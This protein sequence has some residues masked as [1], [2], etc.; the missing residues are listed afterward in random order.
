MPVKSEVPTIDV[1]EILTQSLRFSGN[2]E[3]PP[4]VESEDSNIMA[5]DFYD[6]NLNSYDEGPG[7]DLPQQHQP[8]AM[9]KKSKKDNR[10]RVGVYLSNVP[11]A[12][13]NK[14]V[15]NL[16]K[17]FG[18]IE[19]EANVW[20]GDGGYRRDN[21]SKHRGGKCATVQFATLE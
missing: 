14:G 11:L 15:E 21:N 3:Q 12:L 10:E 20:G 18:Q 4:A 9:A 7:S 16:C 2:E 17:K 6:A 13:E 5:R 19:G 1:T 8:G